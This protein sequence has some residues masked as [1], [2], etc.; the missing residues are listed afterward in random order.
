M[1]ENATTPF[2]YI[3]T[4]VGI[5]IGF[6]QAVMIM[7]LL[8]LKGDIKDLWDRVYNHY[9]EIECN[10]ADCTA[11]KTGNVVVPHGGR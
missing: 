1:T 2:S 7:L 11:V 5:V 3:I 8:G 10:N 6:M 9:H 4:L